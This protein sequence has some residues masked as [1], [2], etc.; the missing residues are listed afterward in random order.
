MFKRLKISDWRQFSNVDISFHPHLTVLTGAN[1]AGK[2]TILN[3]LSQSTGWDPQFVSSYEK[4]KAGI[5]KYFNSLKNIGK[6]FF[7]KASNTPN[8]V[9]NKL[10]ELEFSDGTIADLILPQN[11]SSGTYSITTK[12]GKKEKGVCSIN[13]DCLCRTIVPREKYGTCY[14]RKPQYTVEEK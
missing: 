5:S 6:R 1:G 12:G 3:L 4:D 11:V 9:E 2:T 8:A 13:S 10:G 7:I 14:R